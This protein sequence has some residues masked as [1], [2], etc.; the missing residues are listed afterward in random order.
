[1]FPLL[2]RGRGHEKLHPVLRGGPPRRGIQMGVAA[3]AKTDPVI[4]GPIAL[5]KFKTWK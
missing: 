1:M 2:K 5:L 3:L 4:T